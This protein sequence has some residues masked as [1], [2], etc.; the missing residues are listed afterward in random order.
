MTYTLADLRNYCRA[1]QET[2]HLLNIYRICSSDK[3]FS[4][5]TKMFSRDHTAFDIAMCFIVHRNT[6]IHALEM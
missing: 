2:L 3:L 4:I 6:L 1:S 5:G